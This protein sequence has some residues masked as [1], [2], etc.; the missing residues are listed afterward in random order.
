MINRYRMFAAYNRWANER[1]YAAA[2]KLSDAE[3]R[4]DRGAFFK[5]VHGTLNHLLVADRIWMRRFTGSGDTPSRLDAILFDDLTDLR[6]A[7]RSEDER[8]GR[9]VD[10]LEGKLAGPLSYVS[11][12]TITNPADV[13]QTLSSALDHFFSHQTHHRGQVHALLTGL[14][15]NAFAPSLDLLVFQRESGMAKVR[16]QPAG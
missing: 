10:G 9:Y 14:R 8:I 13:T 15:G 4:A 11:Y 3:Y 7:R 6:A 2:G 5:S 12:R 1:L 16:F